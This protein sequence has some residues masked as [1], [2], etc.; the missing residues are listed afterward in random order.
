MPE[1]RSFK[2]RR[3]PSDESAG[4]LPPPWTI[5]EPAV[6]TYQGWVWREGKW[7]RAGG[8]AALPQAN[9]RL[10]AAALRLKVPPQC[11]CLTPGDSP[12]WGIPGGAAD[13]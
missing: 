7:E 4:L 13:E 1:D 8:R 2:C 9:K 6:P 11:T 3:R 12:P 5:R 10:A